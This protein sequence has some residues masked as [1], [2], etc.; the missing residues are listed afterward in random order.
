MP[1]A[2]RT[3]VLLSVNSVSLSY[4]PIPVLR[5]CSFIVRDLIRPGCVT[6]QTLGLLGPSGI[7]KST[8]LRIIAGLQP[9]PPHKRHRPPRAR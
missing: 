7:G 4:G 6:G 5:D 2:Q 9:P 8:L 1:E 3:D